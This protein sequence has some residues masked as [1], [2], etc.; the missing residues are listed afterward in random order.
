MQ[1]LTMDRRIYRLF[2]IFATIFIIII[3]RHAY[4][5]IVK[6][7]ELSNSQ[8]NRRWIYIEENSPRG[9]ILD[10]SGVKLAYTENK[11]R[12]YIP[13]VS[14]IVGYQDI[15]FG[16]AGLER[17]FHHELSGAN[18]QFNLQEL[19]RILANKERRGN[20]IRLTLD[21][22]LQ[23]KA[24]EALKGKTG[25]VALLDPKTGEILAL[26]SSPTFNFETDD[27][28]NLQKRDDGVLLNRAIN[29]IYPPGSSAKILTA[30]AALKNDIPVSTIYHCEG[31]TVF[32][33]IR[34]TD[35]RKSSHGDIDMRDAFKKSCNLYFGATAID[36]GSDSLLRSADDLMFGHDIR[37]NY[38]DKRVMPR[39]ATSNL[40]KQGAA[41]EDGDLAQIGYGQGTFVTTP[42]QMALLAGAVANDGIIMKP[43]LVKSQIDEDIETLLFKEGALNRSMP[44]EVA[45]KVQDMMWAVVNE[46]GTGTAARTK[47]L[48]IYGKTGTAEHGN[49]A[50][51][52][53]FVGYAVNGQDKKIA[54]AIIIENGGGGGS[55]AAP[56][57]S[58]ILSGF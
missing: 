49:G 23:K 33:K 15:K 48:K 7:D 46:G 28:E 26:A 17:D 10:R 34:I 38:T 32:N 58:K 24:S 40:S 30:V 56:L 8:T 39:A 19:Q 52:G 12:H 11:T 1:N 43:Y 29:Y 45:K 55:A 27:L 42:F 14:S 22:K 57:V 53:W 5:A 6:S 4:L 37:D 21:Y 47:G 44:V 51:H 50:D 25:A 31:V 41:I 20:D 36:I 3:L 2:N 13:Y 9:S 54:F 18:T 16:R 35:Y